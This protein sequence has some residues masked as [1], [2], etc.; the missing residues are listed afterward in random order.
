MQPGDWLTPHWPAPA[1]VRALCTT[2]SGGQSQPP[3]DSLNLG[4]HVGDDPADVRATFDPLPLDE[5]A[6]LT[7]MAVEVALKDQGIELVRAKVGDRYV[8][9]E[10]ASRGA[11]SARRWEPVIKASGFQA[12]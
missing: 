4:D 9:E 2:R 10:L 3:Y 11:A 6:T 5:R 8:L 12:D 7:N 1:S